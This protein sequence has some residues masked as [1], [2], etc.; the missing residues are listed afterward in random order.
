MEDK[1]KNHFRISFND[2]IPLISADSIDELEKKISEEKSL[3]GGNDCEVIVKYFAKV[4]I[5]KTYQV[6]D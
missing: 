5:T 3:H 1:L 2:T 6:N 4:L